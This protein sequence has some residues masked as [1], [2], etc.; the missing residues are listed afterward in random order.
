MC[1]HPT[2]SVD[3]VGLLSSVPGSL[4]AKRQQTDCYQESKE[5]TN[6]LQSL[7]DPIKADLIR[8]QFVEFNNFYMRVR[9]PRKVKPILFK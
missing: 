2:V 1:A 6:W 8:A 4:V 5:F 9:E 3:S 7:I